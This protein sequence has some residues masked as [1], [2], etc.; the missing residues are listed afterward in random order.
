MASD[1]HAFIWAL[2]AAPQSAPDKFVHL[3]RTP[4]YGVHHLDL[5][6]VTKSNIEQSRRC[7]GY[8]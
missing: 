6:L 7:K 5:A 4:C 2:F 3:S 8:L 1:A